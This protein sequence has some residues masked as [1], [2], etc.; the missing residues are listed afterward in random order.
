MLCSLTVKISLS[1]ELN[2]FSVLGKLQA[3]DGF[4]LFVL[5][6]DWAIFL[7]KIPIPTSK[8]KSQKDYYES[9]LV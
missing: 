9:N 8:D 1:T 4:R 5:W 2:K 3:Q 6:S 7:L